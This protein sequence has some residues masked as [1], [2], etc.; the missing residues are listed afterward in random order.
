MKIQKEHNDYNQ[1][2]SEKDLA[3]QYKLGTAFGRTQA[4]S[5]FKE[6]LK[7]QLRILKDCIPCGITA[8]L[9]GKD[10][11]ELQYYTDRVI[12]TTMNYAIEQIDKTAQEIK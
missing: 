8:K 10:N 11:D 4:I 1:I 5:E 6:K 2:Y 3:K 12:E 7:E 9:R